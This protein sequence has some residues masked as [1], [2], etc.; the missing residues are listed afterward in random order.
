MRAFSVVGWQKTAPVNWDGLFTDSSLV[1]FFFLPPVLTDG[2][3]KEKKRSGKQEGR[4]GR[5]REKERG[6]RRE[7]KRSLSGSSSNK[8]LFCTLIG[9][10]ML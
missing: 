4:K 5:E 1:P 9:Q 8:H 7:D 2:E 3:Q 10:L 6:E